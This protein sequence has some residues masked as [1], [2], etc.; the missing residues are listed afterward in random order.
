[1]TAKRKKSSKRQPAMDTG[2][3]DVTATSG[4]GH[5]LVTGVLVDGDGAPLAGTPV[6]LVSIRIRSETTLG[7]AKTDERG[8]YSVAYTWTGGL[9]LLMRAYGKGGRV[10]AQSDTVFAAAAQVVIDFTTAP[11]GIVVKPS[12]LSNL[13][14]SVSAQLQGVTLTSLKQNSKAQE[15]G[16]LA[17]AVQAPF[18]D[19]V[20]LYMATVL[21]AR[22]KLSDETLFGIFYQGIPTNLE[23]SLTQLPDAGIDAGF[24]GQAFAGILAHSRD[25]LDRA[26]TQALQ[27]NV[28]PA[29]YAASQAAQLDQIDVLRQQQVAASPYLGGES[30]LSA[31]LTAGNV[32]AN[33]ASAFVQTFAANGSSLPATWSALRADKSL[34]AS[35]LST[36]D[37]ALTLGELLSGY[38]LL[39]QDTLSR[40]SQKTLGSIQDLALLDAS[41]W[42][43][44][45]SAVDPQ[46]TGLPQGS[47]A[48]TAQ[49]PITTYAQALAARF[50]NRYPTTAFV[51]GLTNAKQTSF[52]ITRQELVGFFSAHPSFD[53]GSTSLDSFLVTNQVSLSVAALADLKTAQRLY[54]ISPQYAS[55]D[56]LKAA[57]YL[58]AQSIYFQGRGPFLAQ[59]SSA[60]GGAS[61]AQTAYARATMTYATA[62]TVYGRFNLALNGVAPAASGSA[63]PD[64]QTLDNLPDLQALFGSLD[65]FQCSDCE[66]IVSPAAYLVDLLQ[67][68]STIA[69]SGGSVTNAR[70]ALLLRR[71]DIQ[72]IALDCSNTNV[73]MPYIDIAN[74]IFESAIAPPATAVTFIDTVGTSEERRALPQQISQ[75][76]YTLTANAVFPLNLPFDLPFAQVSAYAAALGTARVSLLALWDSILRCRLSS[77][78]PTRTCHGTAGVWRNILRP[79][80]IPTHG[81]PTPRTR[82]TGLRRWGKYRSS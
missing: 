39:I 3:T 58:S 21:A 51:G 22:H 5:G 36:L 76:A 9:N 16:F 7:E 13:K 54:R 56:A 47:P 18:D 25:T 10:I 64:P 80:S 1:M 65:Y 20:Y 19:A 69:A 48:D 53:L 4:S 41:D 29:S 31:L 61:L 67:Y 60:L 59:M 43:A 44:R 71:P 17:D 34:S 45:I 35:D 55:V 42:A 2:K 77:S 62:V 74:E 28:L 26:L 6:A 30:A 63:V 33:V 24:I 78:A 49:P 23:G 73:T 12:I 50:A 11:S 75:A 79:S 81:S 52:A 27:A 82:P 68:L 38:L 40:L 8:N 46:G 14:Q 15:L 37:T 70:D 72:Y 66:S 57:G 32:P